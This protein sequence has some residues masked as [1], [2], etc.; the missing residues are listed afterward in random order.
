[1][2][3]HVHVL[4]ITWSVASTVMTTPT[5]AFVPNVVTTNT[6]TNAMTFS[7]SRL[8]AHHNH[9]NDVKSSENNIKSN[10]NVFVNAMKQWTMAAMVATTIW[11][12]PAAMAPFAATHAVF[13]DNAIINTMGVASAKD[14]ASGSGSR[15]N[16]DPESLLRYG[17]PI[18][19][20][21]V[22]LE[23]TQDPRLTCLLLTFN[24][25]SLFPLTKFMHS[26]RS[27]PSTPG[28]H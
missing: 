3:F 18:Q 7:H 22:S 4:A 14:K 5:L 20:K 21:E 13:Q 26:P 27:G 8:L 15:V 12:S 11:A 17:L 19:N 24:I 2:R 25:H 16:K 23:H 28:C 1:M 10:N 6:A 9:H